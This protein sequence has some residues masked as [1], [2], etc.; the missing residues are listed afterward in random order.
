MTKPT[1]QPRNAEG[2]LM[3]SIEY[4]PMIY[5]AGTETHRLALH[6]SLNVHLPESRKD[7]HVSDPVTG[8]HAITVRGSYKGMPCSS[9]G[10][11]LKEARAAAMATMD[12]FLELIGSE[13][14]NS[15]IA[16]AKVKWAGETA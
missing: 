3:A 6:K 16:K 11:G 1:F 14:F 8:L 2:K 9:A 5:I 10:L 15:T 12:E 4:T 13:R 7:W